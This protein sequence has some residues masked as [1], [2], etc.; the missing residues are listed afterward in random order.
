MIF[1]FLLVLLWGFI[2]FGGNVASETVLTPSD[3]SSLQLN[4]SIQ[5]YYHSTWFTITTTCTWS[6]DCPGRFNYEVPVSMYWVYSTCIFHLHGH[7]FP[8][9]DDLFWLSLI[10]KVFLCVISIKK[11]THFK[12][13]SPQLNQQKCFYSEKAASLNCETTLLIKLWLHCHQQEV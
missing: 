11:C 12:L 4:E 6:S 3:A 13:M 8:F 7:T 5:T 10:T 9:E 2:F 1:F